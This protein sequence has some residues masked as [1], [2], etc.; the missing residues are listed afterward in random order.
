MS[1]KRV[2]GLF[3]LNDGVM[4]FALGLYRIIVDITTPGR[5]NF[6]FPWTPHE[7]KYICFTAIGLIAAIVGL[8][9]AI[10]K[11]KENKE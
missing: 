5:Y 9:I 4:V 1:L 7:V 6:C 8:I 11:D 2:I 3:L 10:K